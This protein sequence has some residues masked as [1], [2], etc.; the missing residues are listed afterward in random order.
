MWQMQE[1]C[2]K[3]LSFNFPCRLQILAQQGSAYYEYQL[4]RKKLSLVSVVLQLNN[5]ARLNFLQGTLTTSQEHWRSKTPENL[6]TRINAHPKNRVFI[7]EIA[8]N[9]K[10]PLFDKMIN[11]EGK[12]MQ[13]KWYLKLIDTGVLLGSHSLAPTRNKRT[14]V[15]CLI[16]RI[17]HATSGC[18]EFDTTI[19]Y[20]A[21]ILEETRSPP[22]FNQTIVRKAI[23][24]I[25][26]WVKTK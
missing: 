23:T 24:K 15:E 2:Y 20:A 22:Q 14:V 25:V 1:Q 19:Q 16:H 12:S 5:L 9:R 17:S 13:S 18:S 8:T 11:K 6:L 21:I 7:F 26:E 3:R 10:W 4:F